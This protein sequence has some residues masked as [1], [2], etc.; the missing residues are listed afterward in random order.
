MNKLK[1]I[2]PRNLPRKNNKKTAK[3]TRIP[4][5]CLS[6]VKKNGEQKRKNPSFRY[7]ISKNEEN[8][9]TS[10]E[11]VQPKF[12]KVKFSHHQTNQPQNKTCTQRQPHSKNGKEHQEE[13]RKE[14]SKDGKKNKNN[15]SKK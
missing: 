1:P 12:K 6:P 14:V 5:L 11:E 9:I 10:N 8:S 7:Q 15:K 13:R 4:E 3:A 2:P